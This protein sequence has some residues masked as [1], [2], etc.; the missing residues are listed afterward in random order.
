MARVIISAGHT[1]Q[2]P[3]AI[4]GELREV[5]LTKKIA[6]LVAS[7]LRN[8][9]IV[10]LSVPPEL[11]LNSKIDW[12]NK[13][14]YQQQLE[15]IC[16]EFHINEGGKSGIEGWFNSGNEDS[17]RLTE[18]IV[19]QTCK[20]TSLQNQGVKD[21]SQ[22]QLKTLAFL[23]KTNPTA[24]LIECLYIDN[25][26]DQKFLQDET[27]LNLLAEGIVDGILEFF[28]VDRNAQAQNIQNQQ[29]P[30]SNTTQAGISGQT[31]STFRKP[32][33]YKP[34]TT[35][36]SS[37]PIKQPSSNIQPKLGS[38]LSRPS[39]TSRAKTNL[40]GLSPTSPP[41]QKQMTRE[42]RKKMIQEKYE[43]ILGRKVNDKD[44]NY[45]VNLGLNEDQMI[46]RLVESQEHADMVKNSQEHKKIKPEYE[47]L[48]KEVQE[49]RTGVKDKEALVEKQNELIERKTQTIQNLQHGVQ[50]NQ[51]QT[52]QSPQSNTTNPQSP[53]QISQIGYEE[54]NTK[55]MSFI[56][57]ILK[58]LNDLLD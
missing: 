6:N 50:S 23:S 21:E 29:L 44:L 35:T 58:K 51:Q 33:P 27:K 19:T 54:P 43:L 52:V 3:G 5:D 24:S 14:G 11:D 42:E 45:F 15:D 30:G 18:Q 9:G 31:Q 1:Q 40:G 37:Q 34:P 7:K 47:K 20:K 28:E 38:S 55:E 13:T 49:L 39:S 48:K 2:D 53:Q 25:P 46:K 36:K 12:I 56:D 57:K 41:P 17:K 16:V 22:H 8:Q 4:Q 26:E 10:T 32:P